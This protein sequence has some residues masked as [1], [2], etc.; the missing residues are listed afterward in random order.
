MDASGFYMNTSSL[1]CYIIGF[2]SAQLGKNMPVEY[3]DGHH[4]T[5]FN[6]P[7]IQSTCLS[8]SDGYIFFIQFHTK[9]DNFVLILRSSGGKTE[10]QR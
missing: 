2:N 1:H 9:F 3:L 7:E 10:Q 6:E 8:S 4:C 5:L